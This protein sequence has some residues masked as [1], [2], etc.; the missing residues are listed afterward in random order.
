MLRVALGRARSDADWM[1]K[2]SS[3]NFTNTQTARTGTIAIAIPESI[4]SEISHNTLTHGVVVE[5]QK[6][7][8]SDAVV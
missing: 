8:E 2:V 6:S 5:E 7:R 3:V 4:R 1:N